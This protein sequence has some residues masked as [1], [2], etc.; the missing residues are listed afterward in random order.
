MNETIVPTIKTVAT[1][2]G[3]IHKKDSR[4]KG[5]AVDSSTTG[6]SNACDTFAYMVVQPAIDIFR[7]CGTMVP[8]AAAACDPND[9]QPV[10]MAPAMPPAIAPA[11]LLHGINMPSVKMPNVVP[12]AIDDRLVATSRIPPSRSTTRRKTMDKMPRMMMLL[13]TMKLAAFS[14]GSRF[15]Q[16]RQMSS[17]KTPAVEFSTTDNELHGGGNVSS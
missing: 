6:T 15:R 5:N 9:I 17:S 14:D 13:L 11:L 7:R 3:F 2:I 4:Y 12:A 16:P 1:P 8:A 10:M